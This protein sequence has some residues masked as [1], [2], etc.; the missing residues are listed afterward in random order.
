MPGPVLIAPD[1]FKGSLTAPGVADALAAGM[2]GIEVRRTPVADGGDGTV[3]AA[4]AAGYK[5]VPV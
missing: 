1:K 5:S 4:L 2:P 3:Q